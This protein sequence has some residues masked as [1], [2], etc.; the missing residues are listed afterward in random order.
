MTMSTCTCTHTVITAAG[1][2]AMPLVTCYQHL[3][4]GSSG[5]SSFQKFTPL[6]ATGIAVE[7]GWKVLRD[8]GLVA[9]ADFREVS[10]SGGVRVFCE[11]RWRQ[12]ASLSLSVGH[13]LHV[14]GEVCPNR[15]VFN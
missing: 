5:K 10:I 15:Y 13:D 4:K 1:S 2:R 3:E 11:G 9:V 8:R 12:V 6:R 7:S 14:E